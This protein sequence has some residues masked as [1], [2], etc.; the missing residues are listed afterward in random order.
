MHYAL[1]DDV[2]GVKTESL[3]MDDESVSIVVI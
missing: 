1:Y 2:N 3:L